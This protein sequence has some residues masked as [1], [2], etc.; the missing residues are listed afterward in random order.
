LQARSLQNIAHKFSYDL[1]TQ[2]PRLPLSS[3]TAAPATILVLVAHLPPAACAKLLPL[4]HC[5]SSFL[6]TLP[7]F[8]ALSAAAGQCHNRNPGG[9]P[10]LQPLP[11]LCSHCS[12]H[13][14]LLHTL[15]PLLLLCLMQ[16]WPPVAATA[17]VPLT[18]ATCH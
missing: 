16:M 14:N 8:I 7:A 4:C 15:C 9:S 3:T 12:C 1:C 6:L 18:T 17:A 5:H 2:S 11:P 13:C 10:P